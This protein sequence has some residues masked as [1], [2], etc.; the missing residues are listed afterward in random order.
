MKQGIL[1]NMALA[2]M[3]AVFAGSIAGAYPVMNA[4]QAAEPEMAIHFIDLKSN[5][6]KTTL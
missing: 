1:K 6:I 5:A 4:V 2:L 3:A